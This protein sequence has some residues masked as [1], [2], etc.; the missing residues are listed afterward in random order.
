MASDFY[1]GVD[2]S[3][4]HLSVALMNA[5][6]KIIWSNKKIANNLSGF[7]QLMEHTLK[8]ASKSAGCNDFSIAA[9]MES[10][11]TYGEA[12]AYY[13]ADNRKAGYPCMC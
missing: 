10:T 1:L 9:G 12:L 6:G 8:A 3:K 2:V 5:A 11:G 7:R 13:L 4:A